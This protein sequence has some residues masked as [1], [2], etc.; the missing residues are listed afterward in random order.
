MRSL[1]KQFVIAEHGVLADSTIVQT[2]AIQKV[3]DQAHHQGGGVIVVPKG[4]FL[5]GA[6]FFKPKTQLYVSAGAVLK[7]SDQIADYPMI[8]SRMEGQSLDYFPALV[9][10]YA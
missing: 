2:A 4:V 1:G 5:T 10:A 6:L 3:V 7:G 8:P 9:N